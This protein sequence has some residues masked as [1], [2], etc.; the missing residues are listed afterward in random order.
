CVLGCVL[1]WGW[2]SFCA[3]VCVGVCGCG[4]VCC[5]VVWCVVFVVARLALRCGVCV[6]V[7]LGASVCVCVCV[8]VPLHATQG[9][10]CWTLWRCVS[11]GR[12]ERG[13]GSSSSCP[14]GWISSGKG[15]G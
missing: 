14:A 11:P 12:G 8:F 6:C 10:W 15:Q 4:C 1:V 13:W 3:G 2:G 5:G 7:C 9:W